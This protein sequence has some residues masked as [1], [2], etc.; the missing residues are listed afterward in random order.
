MKGLNLAR[1]W[2]ISDGARRGEE[3]GSVTLIDEDYASSEPMV[4]DMR[5][6]LRPL[7]DVDALYS[8]HRG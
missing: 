2:S 7:D 8:G 4:L 1:E 6:L 5:K 3:P